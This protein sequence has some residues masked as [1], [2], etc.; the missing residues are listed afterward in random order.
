ME[1]AR[2]ITE[3]REAL[4]QQTATAEV[5]QVIN[6][7][8]GDLAPV[9]EAILEKAHS[10]CGAP[11][12]SLQIYDGEYFR[13]VS[14]RGLPEPFVEML[15]QGVPAAA[16]G[17]HA[18]F[19]DGEAV[20]QVAD[21]A[22]VAARFPDDEGVQATVHLAGLR[23]ML[24]V[25][26][27]RDDIL[28]GRIVAGSSRGAAVLGQADRAAAELRRAGGDRDGERT[29]DHRT[30][31][32][33]ARSA[34]VARIPDRDQRRAQGHQPLGRRARAG[35]RYAGRDGGAYLPGRNSGFIFRLH[36][37]L[38]R[39]VASFGIPAE[40]KDFQARN[41]IAPGRG[42]LAGRT[43]LER[44]AVHIEDAA[45]DPEYTRAEA[46]QL[47]RQRDTCSGCR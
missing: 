28:L 43:V 12:G 9:F 34:G 46:V 47:G 8:P 2:L 42:T 15:R 20:I 27:R 23:T 13:A 6:S 26:L 16:G 19:V 24:F 3:T 11:C 25:S 45:A 31:A 30:A 40:Y 33:H 22:E 1:N 10:L 29:A 32:A 35:A 18:R 17:I 36:D 14:A 7:S 21:F 38:C 39:M 5:L 4:E 41:P 37:G 44:R